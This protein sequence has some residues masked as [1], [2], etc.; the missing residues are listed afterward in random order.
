MAAYPHLRVERPVR[1][2]GAAD[3]RQPRHA[4]R[5][6]RRDDLVL[7]RRGGRA[8][9]RPVAAGGRGHGRGLG[10]LLGRQHLMDRQRAGRDRGPAARPDAAVLP[11]LALD[12]DPRGPDHRG[13]Q[14][15]RHRRRAVPRARLRPAVRRR[16]GQARRPVREARHARRAWA[17]P[18]C[19][20]RWSARRTPAT[21][22]SPAGSWTP[23]RRSGSGWS[24]G[25]SSRR[26]SSTTCSAIAAGIAAAAPIATR[27]TKLALLDGGHADL[28]TAL[29]WEAMAQPITLATEDLQEGIRAS[30]EKR[31]PEFRGR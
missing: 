7:G 24:R 13:G 20:P 25:C 18:T 15:C 30:R 4:Q 14:R 31:P 27:L 28:E 1:R 17:A 12:P 3:P 29:Q 2:R 19:C 8:G 26:R 9:R 21:C 16:G 10:V 23:T 11:G 6:V 22:C 5:D